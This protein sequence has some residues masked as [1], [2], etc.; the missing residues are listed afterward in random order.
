[1]K[2]MK[3]KFPSVMVTILAAGLILQGCATD[4]TKTGS[5]GSRGGKSLEQMPVPELR[6][7]VDSIGAKY[8]KRPKDKAI[9]LQY[10]SAL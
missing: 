8:Q 4:P 3:K 9:G 1:M 6:Q 10:A 2:L 7:A 5:I